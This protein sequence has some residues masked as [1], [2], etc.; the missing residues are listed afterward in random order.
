MLKPGAVALSTAAL[1][2]F[3]VFLSQLGYVVAY[4]VSGV[5]ADGLGALTGTGVGRG[6]AI[7]ILISGILL[8]IT[9]VTL[10]RFSEIK[11]LEK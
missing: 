1:V 2:I 4:T 6:A 3:Q 5:A 10:L 7:M 11:K 8:A 9:S